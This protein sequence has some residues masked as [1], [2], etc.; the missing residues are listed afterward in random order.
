LSDLSAETIAS[1]CTRAAVNISSGTVAFAYATL[2]RGS[3]LAGWVFA[4]PLYQLGALCVPTD[5]L[6]PS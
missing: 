5:R 3:L 1:I 6:K 4:T 2:M